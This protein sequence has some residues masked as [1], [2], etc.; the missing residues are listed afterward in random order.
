VSSADSIGARWQ[1]VVEPPWCHRVRM[2]VCWPGHAVTWHRVADNWARLFFVFSKLF[3]HPKYEI[4]I[5]ILPDVQNSPNFAGRLFETY[6]A[7]LH[8]GPT[9]KSNGISCYKFWNKF[10]FESY[11]NF[12][13]VQ[14]FLE[15]S[16][17]FSKIPSS[18][19]IVEYEFK[20]SHLYS[21]FESSFTSG[22][23]YFVYFVPHKIWRLN[24]IAPTITSTPLYQTGQRVF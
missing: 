19:A 18:H 24:N 2:G 12:K 1:A 5:G 9:S 21:N 4:R 16:H 13:G 11:L 17:K 3:N 23:L 14:N 10:K 8:F 15:T 6:G 20:L 7:T 22:K